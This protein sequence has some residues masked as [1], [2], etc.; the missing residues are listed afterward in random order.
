MSNNISVKKKFFGG[1]QGL[2]LI[3]LI[4]YIAIFGFVSMV[5][6][7]LFNNVIRSKAA[8]DA[9]IEVNQNLRF[10]IDR[11]TK[12]IQRA[13][14]VNSP[15]VG[16]SGSSLSLDMPGTSEDPLVFDVSSFVLRRTVAAGAATDLTSSKVRITTL[17][18]Q[19]KNSGGAGKSTI[20][21]DITMEYNDLGRPYLKYANSIKTTVS[22]R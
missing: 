17:N 5:L 7:S 13:A 12:D 10:A 21:I 2:G 15:T 9:K 18:F 19:H 22:L 3:E 16:A 1:N 14:A 6:V 4:I 11:I 8:A 20:I